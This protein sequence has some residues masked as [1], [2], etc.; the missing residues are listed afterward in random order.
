M[1]DHPAGFCR[2]WECAHLLRH[3]GR[4]GYHRPGSGVIS[5]PPM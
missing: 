2:L 4:G 1:T 5:S 3:V